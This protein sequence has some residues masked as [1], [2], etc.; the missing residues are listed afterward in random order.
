MKLLRALLLIGIF[1]ISLSV[2]AYSQEYTKEIIDLWDKQNIPYNKENIILNETVDS[3]GRR[4]SQISVPKLYVY[5]RSNTNGNGAGLLYCPGGGYAIV[6]IKNDGEEFAKRFL[7]MGFNVVTVLKYRLPDSRIV[8]SPEKVPLCDAQKALALMHQNAEKWQLDENKVA[9]MGGSAGGHLAA[10]LA[11]LTHNIVAP[12]VNSEELKQAV[13]ILM[14]PVISFNL[15]YRHKGSYKRL[16][17]DKS[18]S[19][20]LLDYYSMENQVSKNTPPTYLIHATDDKS[21][22]F[23]NSIIYFK[24]LK[25]NG[26]PYKYVQLD[27]GGHGF[28]FNFSKTGVDWTVGLEEWLHKQTDLFRKSKNINESFTPRLKIILK[29]DDLAVKDGVCACLP[30]FEL[31]KKKQIK[32]SFGIIPSRCDSTILQTLSSYIQ[33]KNKKDETLFEIWHH[34]WDHVK[35][36]FQESGYEYQKSHFEKADKMIKQ[37][38]GIQM[39]T[40]G[41]PYNASDSITNKV[42]SENP[43]YRTFMFSSVKPD[44]PNGIMYL[45]NRVNMENGTGNPEFSYFVE[46]YNKNKEKYNDYMILQGHP[47][48]WAA[49]KINQFEKIIDFLISENCEFVLPIELAKTTTTKNI[50]T[51]INERIP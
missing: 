28:G 20:T 37:Y 30:T 10:S 5:R 29:L 2:T 9:I 49:D 44:V 38:L 35:P 50:S 15:P 14:Y 24:S 17:V 26:V 1:T 45:D 27:K 47:N 16:L 8:N 25:A 6:S 21:V 40:F 23:Q 42:V 32:A 46:N 31:L 22:S 48:H 41:T 34:G 13:S 4:V 18:S 7:Q 51:K 12:G 43:H 36:E 11:N 3:T 33:S 39:H 19:Q